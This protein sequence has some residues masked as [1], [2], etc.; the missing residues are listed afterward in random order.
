VEKLREKLPVAFFIGDKDPLLEGD[1]R[2]H[3]LLG[4]LNYEHT[5]EEF[6]GIDHNLIKL[7][8]QVKERGLV[9]AAKYFSEP[10]RRRGAE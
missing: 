10:Q 3:A 5:Y 6:P 1:R 8:G 4:E 9:F 7:T 2:L